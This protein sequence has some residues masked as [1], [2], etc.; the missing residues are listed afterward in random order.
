MFTL[1]VAGTKVY[2][3]TFNRPYS[4][5]HFL[6]VIGRHMTFMLD[7]NDFPLFFS[8]DES[9]IDFQFATQ[10]F[11][12][13]CFGVTKVWAVILLSSNIHRDRLQLPPRKK[14]R[15][16]INN[17]YGCDCLFRKTILN[18]MKECWVLC[19]TK[20]TLPNCAFNSAP[21]CP[22]Y[23]LNIS[24][25]LTQG[26]PLPHWLY[27]FWLA[28]DSLIWLFTSSKRNEVLLLKTMT[29]IIFHSSTVTL[30]G[31]WPLLTFKTNPNN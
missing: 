18:S 23:L 30:F 9:V 2:S 26:N 5:W 22:A 28:T 21:S 7:P 10:P 1:H 27:H 11:L 6:D 20:P 12:S 13:R 17:F 19:D 14:K 31:N 4:Y 29:D 15:S 25:L 3:I 8:K 24:S 16:V